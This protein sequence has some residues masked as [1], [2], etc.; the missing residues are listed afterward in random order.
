[1]NKR[2][3]KNSEWR[4]ERGA[5]AAVSPRETDT[6]PSTERRLDFSGLGCGF[7]ANKSRLN[8]KQGLRG[9]WWGLVGV[10]LNLV[11]L[12]YSSDQV[13]PKLAQLR[14][15]KSV[16]VARA[17]GTTPLI[18]SAGLRVHSHRGVCAL[19]LPTVPV[20]GGVLK[21]CWSAGV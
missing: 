16:F 18:P 11:Y 6:S 10:Q 21:D 7:R 3:T 15:I 9:G 12:P 17:T 4:R 1:M 14:F 8:I 20:D 2:W 13:R 5:T 19:F